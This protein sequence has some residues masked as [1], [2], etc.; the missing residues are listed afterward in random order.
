MGCFLVPLFSFRRRWLQPGRDFNENLISFPRSLVLT[1]IDIT[2]SGLP[3]ITPDVH[4]EAVDLPLYRWLCRSNCAT[5]SIVF[6]RRQT[7]ILAFA[8]CSELFNCRLGALEQSGK[9]YGVFASH[10]NRLITAQINLYAY[11]FSLIQA[12]SRCPGEEGVI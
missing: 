7:Q 11:F 2:P 1:Q 8:D 3:C 10:I 4:L 5:F 12:Q 9:E 6:N